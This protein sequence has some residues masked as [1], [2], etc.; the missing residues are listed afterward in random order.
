MS[1]SERAARKRLIDRALIEAGWDPIVPYMGY[2]PPG[3]VAVMEHPTANGPV[4]YAL[5]EKGRLL[6]V[7]E[8]KRPDVGPQNVLKQAQRYS[9]GFPD[10]PF[11]FAGFHV[12]FGYSTNGYAIWFQDLRD[13]HGRSREVK[14]F[15]S[16]AALSAM[17][18]H[19]QV[20][21]LQWLQA[22]AIDHAMLRPYQ[23][24]AIASVE[25]ALAKGQRNLMVAMA[26]GTGKTL[27][28]IALLYRLMR[29]GYARRVLFLVDRRALAAQAVVAFSRFEAEPGLRAPDI[30]PPRC[31]S[32]G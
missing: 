4:D 21:A 2:P 31:P 32:C 16:P 12:P 8:A 20:A 9:R 29:S 30:T 11:D 27:V 15:H 23:R 6:A 28:A 7:V 25:G 22:P 19:D 10:S 1:L 26:T 18:E 24:E 13:P 3:P 14:G 5:L 17:L